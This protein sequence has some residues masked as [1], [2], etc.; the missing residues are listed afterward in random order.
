MGVFDGHG[1]PACA[2][3]ISKRILKYIAASLLPEHVLN[4]LREQETID[5]LID[6]FNDKVSRAKI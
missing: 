5:N 2:Q 4:N 6:T 3:V 1:G